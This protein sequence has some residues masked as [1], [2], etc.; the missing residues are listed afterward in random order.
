MN[1]LPG[2]KNKNSSNSRLV[3]R[4]PTKKK[5]SRVI[6]VRENAMKNRLILNN[7]MMNNSAM[8]NTRPNVLYNINN[9][10]L[11]GCKDA[12]LVFG[13]PLHCE[14]DLSGL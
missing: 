3:A 8:A 1:L 10:Q 13:H 12:K 9:L 14:E 7:Q 4:V 2:I 11:I 6:G 5:T